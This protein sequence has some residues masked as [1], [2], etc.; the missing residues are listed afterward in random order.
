MNKTLNADEHV[1]YQSINNNGFLIRFP[2]FNICHL[3][4]TVGAVV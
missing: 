3:F 1:I 4:L 2:V